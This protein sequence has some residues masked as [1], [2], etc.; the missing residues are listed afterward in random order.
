VGLFQLCKEVLRCR[1]SPS[2]PCEEGRT[3]QLLPGE[4]PNPR[5]VSIVQTKDKGE[6]T[7]GQRGHSG[8]LELCQESFKH[9]FIC[10][11]LW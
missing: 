6:L 8:G 2:N 1:S 4:G 5:T 9:R 11:L 7:E 10:L 3:L